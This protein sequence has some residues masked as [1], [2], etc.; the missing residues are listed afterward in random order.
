MRGFRMDASV[1]RANSIAA[2]IAIATPIP[3]PSARHTRRNHANHRGPWL[4][5]FFFFFAFA[6]S[7]KHNILRG[8]PKA[9]QRRIGDPDAAEDT[10]ASNLRS[11]AFFHPDT[12][13]NKRRVIRTIP[14]CFSSPA[15]NPMVRYPG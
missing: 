10:R 6:S 8:G 1:E 7:Q 9:R 15:A 14:S 3:I 11:H 4:L 5:F 12:A 2:A 13:V